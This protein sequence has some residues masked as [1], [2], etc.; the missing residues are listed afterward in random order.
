MNT[1]KRIIEKT[2]K[3]LCTIKTYQDV[4][5]NGVTKS[6]PIDLIKN[7]PCKLS[8]SSNKPANQTEIQ[9]DITNT[10]NLFISPDIIVPA[11][12]VITVTQYGQTYNFKQTGEPFTYDSHQEISVLVDK[13]V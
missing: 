12:S 7:Q 9:A 2:Y 10:H 4:K 6:K 11:G 5:E 3:G 13:N 8:Q 1:R